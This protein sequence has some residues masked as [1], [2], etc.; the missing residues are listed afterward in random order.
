MNLRIN[1]RMVALALSS[2]LVLS[3]GT[4]C[5]AKE[6][7]TKEDNSLRIE[8]VSYK[9]VIEATSNV[10]LRSMP[11]LESSIYEV[12]P[13][14]STM[15]KISET[16][17]FYVVDYN[18]KK[19][20]IS[21]DYS[22]EVTKEIRVNLNNPIK[23]L[24]YIKD[25]TSIYSDKN[26][27]NEL[28]NLEQYE[29]CEVYDE[30]L[31]QYEVKTP[32]YEGYVNKSSCGDLP[33][34]CVVVDI[35][36]QNVKLYDNKEV[37]LES[38]VVTGG[39]KHGTNIGYHKILQIRHDTYLK[40]PSWNCHVN[41]FAKFDNDAEGLHDA[42]WRKESEFGGDT[43]LHNGSHGCVNMPSEK[44][45]TLIKQLNLGDTVIVKR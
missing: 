23:K 18:G 35:S 3:H 15:D 5:S 29:V 32:D 39:P 19:A 27:K 24:V 16:D 30:L 31:T 10:N 28:G 36:D 7:D 37:T 17:E 38:P 42:S 8:T 14:G 33:S 13:K 43:Y 44:A 22:K 11:S 34:K 40:G 4:V 41:D 20:Y 12:L 26:H 9:T 6:K 2:A 45:K 25:N 21:K 1:K